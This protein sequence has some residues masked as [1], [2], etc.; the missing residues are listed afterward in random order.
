MCE[1]PAT[2]NVVDVACLMLTDISS[3]TIFRAV[4]IISVSFIEKQI[5]GNFRVS[6]ENEAADL[7]GIG[8]NLI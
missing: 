6:N 5:T 1:L 2:V 4:C 3:Q 8:L 7:S